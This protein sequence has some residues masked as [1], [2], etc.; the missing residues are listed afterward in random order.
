M[1]LPVTERPSHLDEFNC[2]ASPDVREQA[3][4]FDDWEE[5]DPLSRA[6]CEFCGHDWTEALD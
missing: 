3:V 6:V 4:D 1:G 5:D 2:C